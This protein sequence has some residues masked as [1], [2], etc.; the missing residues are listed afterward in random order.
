MKSVQVRTRGGGGSEIGDFTA[1][2]LYGC[3]LT[4]FFADQ[5]WAS[6]SVVV[7]D[8]QSS[9]CYYFWTTHP[10][11]IN[12]PLLKSYVAVCS[13]TFFSID[14]SIRQ[15]MYLWPKHLCMYI[16]CLLINKFMPLLFIYYLNHISTGHKYLLQGNSLPITIKWGV[17]HVQMINGSIV[18]TKWVFLTIREIR[19]QIMLMPREKIGWKRPPFID[20]HKELSNI[21][22]MRVNHSETI[23]DSRVHR[24]SVN[25]LILLKNWWRVQ[26]NNNWWFLDQSQSCD[27]PQ[28]LLEAL[29]LLVGYFL[30]QPIP[31]IVQLIAHP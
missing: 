9:N 20:I 27:F 11:H 8:H 18:I 1:Y 31:M 17:Y 16:I 12:D 25:A 28:V 26:Y 7:S 21:F 10:S 22:L 5:P 24:K 30:P 13:L 15:C 29:Y 19:W 2:V 3:P 23:S 6:S 4:T 14:D